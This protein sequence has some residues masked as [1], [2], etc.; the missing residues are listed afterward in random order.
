MTDAS[1]ALLQT[2]L[3]RA[4]GSTRAL[5]RPAAARPSRLGDPRARRG[6]SLLVSAPAGF[7]KTTLLAGAG[8]A[9]PTRAGARRWRG[10]PSTPATATPS[11][12]WTYVLAALRPRRPRGRRERAPA[13]LE[14]PAAHRDD[15]LAAL[16]NELSVLPGEVDPGPR[17]LPPRRR[18]GRRDRDD[19]PGRPPAAA[20]APGHQHPR[21]PGAAAGA[22]AGPRRAG[23]GPRRRPAV[24]RRRGGRLPQRRDGPR[25]RRRATSPPW[26]RAPRAGSP[27]CSWPRCRCGAAT[28]P[29]AFIAGFAGDDRFVVDYLVEEVLDRQPDDGAR[30]PAR[31][32]RPGPAHRPAVR[33]GHRPT[34]GGRAMLE[35]LDRAQ[36]VPRPARRPAALVPLPP[37][38]RRR[39][40]RAPARR[41]TRRRRRAAPPGQRL[42]RPDRATRCRRS[43][44]RWPPAT[45]TGPPTWSSWPSRTLRRDRREARHPRAG[46]TTSPTTWSRDRPVLAIGLRRRADV[47]QRVRRRRAHGWATSSGCSSR[48][49]ADAGIVVVDEAELRPAARRHR[50]VPGRAGADRRRPGRHRRARRAGGRPGARGRRPDPRVGRRPGRARL[51][52]ARATST[53]A[54]RGYTD[55]ADGLRR[56]GHIADVLGCSHHARRHRDH[57]GPARDAAAHLRGAP[58]SS[59]PREDPR[60]AGHRRHARRAEP[61]SPGTQRPGRRGRAPAPRR[62]A[63]RGRRPAA[64][65]VPVAGRAGP[66]AR[67]RGRPRRPRSSCSTRPSG[68]TSATSP[69]TCARSRRCGPACWPRTGDVAAALEWARGTG[70]PPT[71]TCPTCASTSTS[72]WPGSC[73]PSTRSTGDGAGAAPTRSG[74]STGCLRG[75]GRRRDGTVIEILVLLALAHRRG[76]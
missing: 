2:K 3:L 30:L 38:L 55:A 57:P 8:S 54:H 27:P 35:P 29:P 50:D 75:R 46:S 7:G 23:R 71:T 12:F 64:E 41:A 59:P 44:T 10:C 51:V 76:R 74:C 33:R 48:P 42:V 52:D 61:R 56:A 58:S 15:V 1:V 17:R 6:R 63:R 68:S 14:R 36:P 21:R 34:T 73:S 16:L 66:A 53:A 19:V 20:A 28:T 60:H 67:G 32:L 37:P 26:R 18:P 22:A 31:D 43:G 13:L 24:H 70:C 11:T 69:R 62:R 72:P 47:Q 40:A 65:P 49:D 9:D 4:R 39:A 25:P 5:R 45:S